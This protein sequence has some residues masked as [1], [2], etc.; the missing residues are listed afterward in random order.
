MQILQPNPDEAY[1]WYKHYIYDTDKAIESYCR[2][3]NFKSKMPDS[4]KWELF[5]AI[6]MGDKARD[7]NV[8]SDLLNHEV[9]SIHD[10]DLSPVEYQYH[11]DSWKK[12]LEQDRNVKHVFVFHTSKLADV[13]V[14]TMDGSQLVDYHDKWEK[15]LEVFWQRP[16][17][18]NIRFRRS[19]KRKDLRT[20]SKII[21][22]IKNTQF[23]YYNPEGMPSDLLLP[24]KGH[25]YHH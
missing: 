5:C 7:E 1:F 4:W 22:M 18:E 6:L 9:K 21:F 17:P 19:I 25:R 20:K 24:L 8:G 13:I 16:Q 12:K 23:N 2:R 3:Y 14:R 15:E 10:E 11:C